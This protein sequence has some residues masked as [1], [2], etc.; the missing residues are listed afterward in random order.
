M[1]EFQPAA[2]NPFSA[3]NTWTCNSRCFRSL[4]PTAYLSKHQMEIWAHLRERRDQNH[5]KNEQTKKKKKMLLHPTVYAY[6]YF[7]WQNRLAY[8]IET[9]WHRCVAPKTLLR[10]PKSM[11]SLASFMFASHLIIPTIRGPPPASN[12]RHRK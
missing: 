10:L 6:P 1:G 4:L 7:R 5:N 8:C 9:H 2:C 12:I 3:S 11:T